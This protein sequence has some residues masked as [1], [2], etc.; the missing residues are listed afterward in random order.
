MFL[1]AARGADRDRRLAD[2]RSCRSAVR[3][4]QAKAAEIYRSIPDFG[5]FLVKANLEGQPGRRTTADLHADGANMLAA[6]LR[7]SAA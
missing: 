1:T 5:G 4:W 2:G 7:R 3:Q 6:A